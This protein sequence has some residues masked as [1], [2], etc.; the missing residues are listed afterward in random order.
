MK[1][2]IA[3][4]MGIAVILTVV[5]LAGICL[6]RVLTRGDR[7]RRSW[8]AGEMD[9]IEAKEILANKLEAYRKRSYDELQYL[10][11]TQ[12]TEEIKASSGVVYQIE[13]QAV[14]DDKEGRNLRVIGAIDDGGFHALAPLIDASIVAPDGSFVGE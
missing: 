12:D 7:V 2:P 3:I 13:F 9:E 5:L 8:S 6:D 4:T 1:R 14:W 10:L 11:H